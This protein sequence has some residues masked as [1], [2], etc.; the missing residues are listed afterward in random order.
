MPRLSDVNAHEKQN[1]V[2][3]KTAPATIIS[4]LIWQDEHIM[5]FAGGKA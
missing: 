4:R 1:H 2:G 5:D 3:R